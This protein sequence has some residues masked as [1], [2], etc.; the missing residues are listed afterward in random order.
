MSCYGDQM[1][2]YAFPPNIAKSRTTPSP[3]EG[4]LHIPMVQLVWVTNV[5]KV[6]GNKIK[7]NIY[8][9]NKNQ[10]QEMNS[11]SERYVNN[12]LSGENFEKSQ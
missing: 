7:K 12:L 9:Q 4:L 1:T 8:T 6:T 10:T 5:T 2:P 3:P 11:N